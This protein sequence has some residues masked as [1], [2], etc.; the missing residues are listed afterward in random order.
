M[1]PAPAPENLPGAL[2]TSDTVNDIDTE[3]KR[4]QSLT[5]VGNSPLG[6][7][8]VQPGTRAPGN[9]FKA[10][11]EHRLSLN[12]SSPTL[13]PKPQSNPLSKDAPMSVEANPLTISEKQ[14][15][16]EQR[17]KETELA[18]KA[19]KIASIKEELASEELELEKLKVA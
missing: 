4:I 5:E 9:L 19:A 12:T 15:T 2:T 18:K 3:I 7:N 1:I 6:V 17:K 10:D 8:I 11:Y 16:Y 13:P 14:K